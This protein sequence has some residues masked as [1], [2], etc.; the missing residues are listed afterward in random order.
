MEQEEIIGRGSIKQLHVQGKVLFFTQEKL[1][2]LFQK[3]WELILLNCDTTFYTKITANPKLEEIREAQYYFANQTFDFIIAFGGGSV[4]DF[5]KAFRFYENRDTKLIAIP[6]TSGT[7]SEATQFAVVYINGEKTSIDNSCIQPNIAVVDSQFSE[8]VPQNIKASCAMDTLCQGLESYWAKKAS[9]ISKN[10]ALKS[11]TICRDWLEKA[12]L[13]NDMI[14]NEKMA[15]AAHLSGKAINISRTT[16]AHALSYKITSEYG[17][18]HGHAVSLSI[19]N[20]FIKNLGSFENEEVLFEA[21]GIRENN[22]KEYFYNLMRKIGLT[23]NLGNMGIYDID[24]IVDSVN[25]ERL[26]NNPR[27]FSKKDLVE[28]LRAC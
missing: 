1:F 15:I 22:I 3:V 24:K 13:T 12:V 14:A 28:L 4:I 11:I 20:L 6:T 17:V 19:A 9:D 21:L 2:G 16:A 18:P 25:I 23:D 5:A 8:N 10:Y 27:K 7:G 26:S